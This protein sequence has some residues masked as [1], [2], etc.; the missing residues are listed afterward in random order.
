M[1]SRV[2]N[3]FVCNEYMSVSFVIVFLFYPRNKIVCYSFLIDIYLK[4]FVELLF[5]QFAKKAR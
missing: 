4:S 2:Q 3:L 5:F 1:S